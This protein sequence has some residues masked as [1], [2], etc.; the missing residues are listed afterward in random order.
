MPRF[1]NPRITT[2]SYNQTLSRKDDHIDLC[3]KRDVQSGFKISWDEITLP[4]KAL[5]EID[6]SE[7]SLETEFLGHVFSSP[8][9]ISSMTG[10]SKKGNT[11]NETLAVFA[12]NA[13]IPM[14]LGSQRYMIENKKDTH[15]RKLRKKAPK[16]QLWANIGAVQLNYGVSPDQ[17]LKLVDD[18]QA[19]ALIVHC[20]PLQEAI[21]AEGD[22][23]FSELWTKLEVVAERISVPLILKETGC[24]LDPKTCKRAVNCG[25]D[26][27]D[28]AG[29]GGTHWGFIEGLRNKSRKELGNT[30]R[31]WGRPTPQALLEARQAVGPHFPIIA[32]GGI[33]NGLDTARALS[34][35]AQF[36]G[37][38]L[39]FL[40]AAEAG[41]KSLEKFFNKTCEELRIA[42][43]CSGLKNPRELNVV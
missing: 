33:R 4:H 26:A 36:C 39:P 31:N 6:F 42:L 37:L 3:L 2:S 19:Q 7:I 17:L 15:A 5:P 9:L 21:Q 41:P 29:L 32:S 30:F 1:E 28:I 34:L 11:L 35:G 23:N 16:A 20:N 14:G 25:F 38:A 8:F 24:G 18:L 43:F 40:K 13:N 10:G 27:L 22:R 12:Q